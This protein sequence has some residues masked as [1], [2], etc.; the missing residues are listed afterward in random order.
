MNDSALKCRASKLN[1]KRSEFNSSVAYLLPL[2]P[3]HEGTNHSESPLGGSFVYT[4]LYAT[5]FR[6]G[7]RRAKSSSLLG[8][9]NSFVS[10][11]RN[12]RKMLNAPTESA[13]SKTPSCT[14]KPRCLRF[15][16]L[17]N[18]LENPSESG[19][20]WLVYASLRTMRRMPARAHLY[21]I[22]S[23]NFLNGKA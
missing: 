5:H 9:L 12:F 20:H 3:V 7:A 4:F 22:S 10:S 1:N 11:R 16:F 21:I 23:R 18:S 17:E 15:C 2:R 14:N 13:L 19:G 6:L 8:S